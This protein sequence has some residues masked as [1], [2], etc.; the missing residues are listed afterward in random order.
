M[1]IANKQLMLVDTLCASYINRNMTSKHEPLIY[2]FDLSYT[3]SR[4]F[5]PSVKNNVLFPDPT[6]LLGTCI[7]IL[8]LDIVITNLMMI[9]IVEY[10]IVFC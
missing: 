3:A 5:Y 7:L 6:F 1:T 2:I 10:D 4:S 8:V 9:L